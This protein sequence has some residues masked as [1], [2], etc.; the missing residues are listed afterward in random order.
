[1]ETIEIQLPP[2][3]MQR[4]RQE[5]SSDEALSQVVSE[6]IQRWLE[7]GREEKTE[8]EKG[9]QTLRQAGV[10][11]DSAR[12]RAWTEAT[13]ATLPMEKPPTR[14]QVEA[15]LARLSVPLSAEIIAM[16]GKR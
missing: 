5:V 10:V 9:L 12:Q 15:S 6:A 13:M 2:T 16:R 4:I 8:K 14:A 3:L 7:R 1:M 11:M